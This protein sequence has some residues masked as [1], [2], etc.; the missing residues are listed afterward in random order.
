MKE[1]V[2]AGASKAA[3]MLLNGATT[4]NGG[5]TLSGTVA[6]GG[7][8]QKSVTLPCIAPTKDVKNDTS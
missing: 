1:L 8:T 4:I 5:S 6:I 2:R 3:A 7:A